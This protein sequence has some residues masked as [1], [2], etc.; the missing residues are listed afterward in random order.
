MIIHHEELKP[1]RCPQCNNILNE[2]SYQF[3]YRIYNTLS[4]EK[5]ASKG[6]NLDHG[7]LGDNWT[8]WIRVKT[9][10]KMES[11]AYDILSGRAVLTQ[12]NSNDAKLKQMIA[13]TRDRLNKSS[14][15]YYK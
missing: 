2:K 11:M 13:S 12:S 9:E 5:Q 1:I 15:R 14:Q 6:G 4:P 3:Y 10:Q 8:K 7:S